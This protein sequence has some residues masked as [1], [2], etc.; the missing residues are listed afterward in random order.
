MLG[1]TRKI[2]STEGWS[3]VWRVKVEVGGRSKVED[4]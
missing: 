3:E 2:V 1:G 4:D